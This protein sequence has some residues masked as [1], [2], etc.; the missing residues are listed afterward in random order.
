[1]EVFNSFKELKTSLF[2]LTNT[3]LTHEI[4]MKI[5]DLSNQTFAKIQK[6]RYDRIV[7]KHEGP[8]DYKWQFVR[9]NPSLVESIERYKAIGSD[10]EHYD[11]EFLELNGRFIL[12]PVGSNHHPNITIL[13]HFFSQDEEKLVIYLKDTTYYDE[14]YYCGFV[15][16]CDRFPEEEF[17]IATLYHEWFVIDYDP[18]ADLWRKGDE[19]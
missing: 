2:F 9:N 15:A 1:M 8:F 18:L 14:A 6:T 4:I 10:L 19:S 12:L 17:Y 5:K 16:I 3:F 7:E 11:A 13:H